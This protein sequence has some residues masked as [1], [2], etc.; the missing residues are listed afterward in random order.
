MTSVSPIVNTAAT[1][2]ASSAASASTA[3]NTLLSPS[4]FM[5]LLVSQLQNQDPTQPMD[6]NAFMNQLVGFNSLETQLGMKQDLDTIAGAVAATGTGSTTNPGA[7]G[8][9][10]TTGTGAANNT[11]TAGLPSSQSS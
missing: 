6:P 9:G 7:T 10:G 5:T 2:A 11:G 1:T 3:G 8:T 4:D